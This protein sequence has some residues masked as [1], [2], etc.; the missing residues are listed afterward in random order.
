[1]SEPEEGVSQD[2]MPTIERLPFGS[3]VAQVAEI[4]ERDGGLILTGVLTPEEVDAVNRE[5]EP[6]IQ[7]YGGSGL[8]EVFAEVLE[9]GDGEDTGYEGARTRHL[10]HCVKHSKTYREKVVASDTLAGYVEAVVPG[11]FG[12]YSLWV[13]VLI[14]ALPGET[15]QDLHRDAAL[16]LRPFIGHGND[17]QLPNVFCNALLALT[18]STEEMGATRLI[19]RSGHWSDLSAPGSQDQTI[20]VEMQA[21]EMFFY[22]GKTLHSGGANTTDHTRRLLATSFTLPYVMGEEAWPFVISLE[23]ARTYPERVQELLGFRSITAMGEKPGF[24][25]RADTKPLEEHLDLDS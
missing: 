5:L 9:S 22:D 20:P 2:G 17:N 12:R 10:Q 15:V 3:D 8:A 16:L 19:P 6:A 23:E 11:T 13:S 1:M 4:V 25:W 7:R 14:D 18:D 21:G 24:F